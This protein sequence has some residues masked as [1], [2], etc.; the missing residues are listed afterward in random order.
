MTSALTLR[1]V[2]FPIRGIQYI[3]TLWLN[4][5]ADTLNHKNPRNPISPPNHTIYFKEYV[6]FLRN[7]LT[8]RKWQSGRCVPTISQRNQIN[9]PLGKPV[10][11][12]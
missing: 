2:Q 7:R 5:F 12:R 4:V 11:L 3:F 10:S 9:V 6:P 8:C 1:K